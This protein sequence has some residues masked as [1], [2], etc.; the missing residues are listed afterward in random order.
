MTKVVSVNGRSKISAQEKVR[1]ILSELGGLLRIVQPGNLVLIKPNFVA[2]FPHAVTSFEILEAVIEQVKQCGGQP[3]VAESSGFEFDTKKTFEILGVYEFAERNKTTLI[4]V[5]D[6]KLT[7]LPLDK[8]LTRKIAVPEIVLEADVIINVPKLKRHSLTKIT[9]GMKNLFGLLSKESRRKLHAYGLERGIFE[10]NKAIKSD[11]V[12]V[13]ASIVTSRAVFG[14]QENLDTIIGGNSVYSVDM[15]CSRLL[16][17]DYNEVK[18]LKLALNDG[19]SHDEYRVLGLSPNKFLCHYNDSLL[20]KLR[21]IEY[22]LAYMTDIPYSW[23]TGGSSLIP[24][25]HYHFGL[26]PEL[27]S[28]RC[29]GCGDCVS[30]CPVNA[31]SLPD[32]RINQKLCM[33]VRCLKCVDICPESAISIRGREVA[34]GLETLGDNIWIG[35]RV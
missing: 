17:L 9:G 5:D 28:K 34:E 22:K 4:N 33:Q 26:R 11:L 23:L 20:K 3:I 16:G 15:F 30:V 13:D 2:P 31:I 24:W 27:D 6:A 10:L 12:I 1:Y 32:K 19:I 18:H 35:A 21:R 7:T 8:G 25:L 29:T 14:K